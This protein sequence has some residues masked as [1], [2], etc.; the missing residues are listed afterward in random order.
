MNDDPK[1]CSGSLDT[2]HACPISHASHIPAK[3]GNRFR[4]GLNQGEAALWGGPRALAEVFIQLSAHKRWLKVDGKNVSE[5]WCWCWCAGASAGTGLMAA[6]FGAGAAVLVWGCS[7][8]TA[9]VIDFAEEQKAVM[10]RQEGRG[11]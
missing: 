9:G 10:G 4:E 11:L 2:H 5:C 3:K 6:G 1:K 8:S 7:W